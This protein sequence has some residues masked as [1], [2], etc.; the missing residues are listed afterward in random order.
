MKLNFVIA[1]LSSF[2]YQVQGELFLTA[3]EVSFFL[4][5]HGLCISSYCH[6]LLSFGDMIAKFLLIS[7]VVS[8]SLSVREALEASCQC[9]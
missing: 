2:V 5:L 6:A 1:V 8:L 3:S 7:L 4:S 9:M